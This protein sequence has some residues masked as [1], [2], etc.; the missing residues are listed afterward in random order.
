[1]TT[2]YKTIVD[3]IDDNDRLTADG[4]VFLMEPDDGTDPSL[5]WVDGLGRRRDKAGVRIELV[6]YELNTT[7][8]S[9]VT[10]FGS[11]SSGDML[12]ISSD[13]H[14]TPDAAVKEARALYRDFVAALPASV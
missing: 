11:S 9:Y 1:M 10:V 2:E 4:L 13:E 6:F 7:W 3:F 14:E 8:Y 5:Y 12:R